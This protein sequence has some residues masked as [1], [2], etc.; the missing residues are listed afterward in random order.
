MQYVRGRGGDSTHVS[1]DY[2]YIICRGRS[3]RALPCLRFP[4][5]ANHDQPSASQ[6]WGR[7]R[8]GPPGHA[9]TP[10]G[11]SNA[12]ISVVRGTVRRL[13]V[14]FVLRLGKLLFEIDQYGLEP[15]LVLMQTI[16]LFEYR[17]LIGID[18]AFGILTPQ[19]H[20]RVGS[21]DGGQGQSA[22]LYQPGCPSHAHCPMQRRYP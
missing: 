3:H 18:G 6:L 8:A 4:R 15:P 20:A 14:L 17:Q 19:A 22:P 11:N 2:N 1:L 12:A 13:H 10:P 7:L 21:A 9:R 5:I 16:P